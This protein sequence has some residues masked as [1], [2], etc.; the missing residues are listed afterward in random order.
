MKTFFRNLKT[1][2]LVALAACAVSCEDPNEGNEPNPGGDPTDQPGTTE[3][4][5]VAYVFNEVDVFFASGETKTVTIRENQPVENLTITAPE[6]WAVVQDSAAL[7]VTAPTEEAVT[8]GTAVANGKVTVKVE[9]EEKIYE[10]SFG[11]YMGATV[12]VEAVSSTFNDIQI[13]AVIKGV[14]EYRVHL[15]TNGLWKDSFDEWQNPNPMLP[16]APEFGWAGEKF[17]VF[18]GSLFDFT[19]DPYTNNFVVVPGTSYDLA[20]LPVVEGKASADYTYSDVKVYALTTAEAGNGGSVTPALALE[21]HTHS[22]VVVKVSAA[23]AYLTY[24]TYYSEADYEAIGGRES[25]IKKDIIANG[26]YS[27]AAEFTAKKDGLQQGSTVYFAAISIDQNGN[28][29]ELVMEPFATEVFLF[30]DMVVTLGTITCDETGKI[31][32]VP[33]STTGGEVDHYRYVYESNDSNWSI[34][35]GGSVEKAEVKIATVPNQYYGPK[36]VYPEELVDGKIVISRGPWPGSKARILVLA[37][38]AEGVPSHA[39]YVEYTP[40]DSSTMII[41]ADEEGYE[42]GMPTVTYKNCFMKT[43]DDG[44]KYPYVNFNVSL[45][46]GTEAAWI[47]GAGEEYLTGR[48]SYE[49]LVEMMDEKAPFMKAEKFTEDGVFACDALYIT[50]DSETRKAIYAMWLDKNGKYHEV[51]LFFDPVD[52]AQDD[53]KAIK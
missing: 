33:V 18:E 30:N 34:Q 14:E 49:L 9:T 27:T 5:N 45:A 41:G 25:V 42:Y 23:N 16:T 15:G 52:A 36:F 53:L 8:A 44:S 32:Y 21:S 38:D 48:T 10:G 51:K 7:E 28:F 22:E 20:I 50:A 1:F 40:Y 19:T 43:F 17:D 47:C 13:K 31:V 6:G 11:V 12:L 46:E 37:M 29:G 26:E 24:Y 35:Y 2:A 39:A 3:K 4:E